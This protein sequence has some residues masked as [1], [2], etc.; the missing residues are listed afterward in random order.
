M[1]IHQPVFQG[2]PRGFTPAV[3]TVLMTSFSHLGVNPPATVPAKASA[4]RPCVVHSSCLGR[5]C[6][7]PHWSSPTNPADLASSCGKAPSSVTM[8][9]RPAVPGWPL[10]TPASTVG[11]D[12]GGG[13]QANA[14]KAPPAAIAQPIRPMVRKRRSR[15]SACGSAFISQPH[16]IEF[17]MPSRLHKNRQKLQPDRE[18]NRKKYEVFLKF[19]ARRGAT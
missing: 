11:V 5:V 2:G 17:S 1:V 9:C 14:A 15:H 7:R 6:A 8:L 3:V 16:T 13:S 18:W 4:P 19:F 10:L 12:A